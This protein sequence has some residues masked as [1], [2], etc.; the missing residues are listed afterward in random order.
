MAKEYKNA[1]PAEKDASAR[2]M[3]SESWNPGEKLMEFISSKTG[4]D[5]PVPP[6]P[7]QGLVNKKAGGMCGGGKT[8][9][10]ASGG[11]TSSVSSRADGIAQRGKTR[12][13]FC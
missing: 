12:G 2:K 13:K 9:K 1:S 4:A 8:K 11:K 3:D 7:P 5:K 6:T 10:M